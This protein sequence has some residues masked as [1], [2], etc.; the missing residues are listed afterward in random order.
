M[1][2]LLLT[3]QEAAKLLKISVPQLDRMWKAKEIPMVPI[4]SLRRF[5]YAALKQWV[6]E[7]TVY[8]RWQPGD[9]QTDNVLQ[10]KRRKA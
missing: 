1:E 9:I 5:P 2:D 7:N 8:G 10:L 4:G 3:K 6:E